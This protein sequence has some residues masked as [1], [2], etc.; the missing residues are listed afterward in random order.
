MNI[1]LAAGAIAVAV[2]GLGIGVLGKIAI[3]GVIDSRSQA[4]QLSLHQE[5][6]KKTKAAEVEDHLQPV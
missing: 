2:I 3:R 1:Y 5:P 6:P 4:I